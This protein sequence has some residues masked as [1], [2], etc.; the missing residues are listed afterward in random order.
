MPSRSLRAVGGVLAVAVAAVLGPV[1]PAL[2]AA[3]PTPKA[4]LAVTPD[5]AEPGAA[6]KATVTL[7]NCTATTVRITG[8]YVDVNGDDATSPSA[9]AT[10]SGTTGPYTAT[11]KVPADAARSDIT[12]QPLHLTAKATCT[13]GSSA[14]VQDGADVAVEPTAASTTKVDP[15]SLRAGRTL[16]FTV[17]GCTGGPADVY[18]EDSKQKFFDVSDRGVTFSKNGEAFAGEF[19]VPTEASTGQ[20]Y[21]VVECSQADT[22]EAVVQVLAASGSASPSPSPSSTPTTA[23]RPAPRPVPHHRFTGSGH[24]AGGAVAPAKPATPVAGTPRFTG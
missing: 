19:R 13:G 16:R 15:K 5:S 14:D 12:D 21:F 9:T 23:P 2:A 1:L 22:S 24:A 3:A 20:G 11:L 18:F 10:R 6:L 17:S 8:T 7:T 4:S